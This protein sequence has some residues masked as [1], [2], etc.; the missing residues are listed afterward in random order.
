MKFIKLLL[1]ILLLPA[2]AALTMTLLALL[3]SIR[4]D[5]G[6]EIPAGAWALAAGFLLWTFIFFALP[7]PVRTYVFAHELSHA[8]WGAVMGARIVR[9]NVAKRS[10][11]VTLTKTNMLIT[12]APYFFP[13]YTVAAVGLYYL[14][15]PFTSVARWQA[16][17]LGIIG[18]TWAFHL[19]FTLRTLSH[20]QP[21]VETHGRLFSYTV[22]YA[23]NMLGI[24]LWVVLVSPATLFQATHFVI[25]DSHTVLALLLRWG[26][27]A[28]T[29]ITGGRARY[30]E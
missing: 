27:A 17:W 4:P 21:D 13:L 29:A 24:C 2:C 11:S 9:M 12:L 8:L 7:R 14:L 22:I 19:T 25:R 28:W 26:I 3:R 18:F 23:M 10:G 5:S 20:E 30:L 16:W 1:G 15:M 6:A